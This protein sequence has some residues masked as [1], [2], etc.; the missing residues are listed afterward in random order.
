MV[1]PVEFESTTTGLKGRCSTVELRTHWEQVM[2]LNHRS[3]RYERDEIDLFSNPQNLKNVDNLPYF[4]RL[5]RGTL[6]KLQTALNILLHPKNA[7]TL[8]CFHP[9]S[10][11]HFDFRQI[12]YMIENERTNSKIKI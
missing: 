1:R 8:P 12:F 5:S 4:H 10:R 7:I 11:G 9:L 6:Q 2:D 3:S